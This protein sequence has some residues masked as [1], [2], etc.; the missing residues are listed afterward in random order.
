MMG[1]L[2]A[3]GDSFFWSAWRPLIALLG[4]R[5]TMLSV[6]NQCSNL[7]GPDSFLNNIQY[8]SFLFAAAQDL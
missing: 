8:S 7:G 5:I 6:K 3:L 4:Q 2:A 1:P